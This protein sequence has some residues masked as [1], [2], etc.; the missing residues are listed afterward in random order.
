MTFFPLGA[1]QG[2]D[3]ALAGLYA[4]DGT[5]SSLNRGRERAC[6]AVPSLEE[7]FPQ[8]GKKCNPQLSHSS[9]N[10]ARFSRVTGR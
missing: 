8:V 10:R 2:Y 5:R 4:L 9:R 6:R 7:N 1:A 3:Q